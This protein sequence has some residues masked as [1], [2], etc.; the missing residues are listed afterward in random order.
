MSLDLSHP[1][2]GALPPDN[3]STVSFAPTGCFKLRLC[4][5]Q[6]HFIHNSQFKTSRPAQLL[7]QESPLQPRERG[8]PQISSGCRALHLPESTSQYRI[9]R[10]HLT[11]QNRVFSLL[12]FDINCR[13]RSDSPEQKLPRFPVQRF[14]LQRNCSESILSW[15]HL[16]GQFKRNTA[17]AAIAPA[18]DWVSI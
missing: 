9:P 13:T 4:I 6:K 11:I 12:I 8:M 3:T 14:T 15:N 5:P 2:I 16:V 1:T 7:A 10:K 18:R 17:I